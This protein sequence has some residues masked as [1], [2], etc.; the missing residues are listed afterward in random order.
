MQQWLV[1]L[2]GR[3]P[4]KKISWTFNSREEAENFISDR[5][6]LIKH[7]KYDPDNSYYIL[8]VE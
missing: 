8:P 5:Y 7:L 6:N 4:D 3:A 2:V 1:G